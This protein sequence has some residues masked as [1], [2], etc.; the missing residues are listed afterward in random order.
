MI[1][2]RQ[3]GAGRIVGMWDKVGIGSPN[4]Q[5]TLDVKGEI[6]G[7]PWYSDAYEWKRYQGPVRMTR[8]D[9]SIC[10]LTLVS[11]YFFGQGEVVQV[12]AGNDGH[13][14]LTGIAGQRDVRAEARCIGAPDG[15]W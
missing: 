2:G 6:R 13:W 3:T 9:Q 10:F 1:L 5:A 8:T 7:K 4:P 15:S 14:W 12:V 11:G